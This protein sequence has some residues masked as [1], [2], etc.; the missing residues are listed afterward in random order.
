MRERAFTLVETLVALSLTGLVLLALGGI[1]QRAASLRSAATRH[2]DDDTDAR[3]LL[4]G[5]ATE[6]EAALPARP[7]DDTAPLELATAAAHSWRL[8]FDSAA[9][10]GDGVSTLAYTLEADRQHPGRYALVRR[11][12]RRPL[13]AGEKAAEGDALLG[14]LREFRVRCF[15]GTTWSATW[16]RSQLPSAIELAVVLEDGRELATT[17]VLARAGH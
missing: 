17:V 2:V 3:G 4:L 12:T 11:E 16:S 8:R 7:S 9:G 15:D 13:P 14:A 1:T 5:L 10:T 6:L